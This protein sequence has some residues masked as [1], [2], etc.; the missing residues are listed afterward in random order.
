MANKPILLKTF[1]KQLGEF[2]DDISN[3]FPGE[4]DVIVLST[5]MYLLEC[6]EYFLFLHNSLAATSKQIDT[7][8]PFT[9][10]D[11]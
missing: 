1:N 11:L 2:I 7:S 9:K 10:P 5:F 8:L 4:K 3:I 6:I